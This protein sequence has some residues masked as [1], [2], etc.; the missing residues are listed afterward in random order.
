MALDLI[1][2]KKVRVDD[3]LTHR[4]RIEEYRTMIEVNL[5]KARHEAMKTAVEF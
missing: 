5:N 2:K 3:M 4:F 1:A